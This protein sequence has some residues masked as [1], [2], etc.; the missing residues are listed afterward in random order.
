MPPKQ[1]EVM[2]RRKRFGKGKSGGTPAWGFDLD[3]MG[4]LG[5][6]PCSDEEWNAFLLSPDQG[7]PRKGPFYIIIDGIEEQEREKQR[8]MR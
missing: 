5:Y 7:D 2:L 4:E 3:L 1:P 8:A 6:Q